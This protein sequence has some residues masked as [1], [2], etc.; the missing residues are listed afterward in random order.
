M[1]KH[2]FDVENQKLN[3]NSR[4]VVGFERMAEVFRVMLWNHARETGLSPIQIQ[5]LIFLDSHEESLRTV[6][7]LAKEFN[8]TKPTISDAIKTLSH[9]EL[10]SKTPGAEDARSYSVGLTNKGRAIVTEVEG[11]TL[12]LERAVDQFSETER[13]HLYK[14]LTKLVFQLHQSEVIAVQRTCFACKFHEEKSGGHYCHFINRDLKDHDI[15]L[16]CED[17]IS[18]EL[19]E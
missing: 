4:I 5:L 15:R 19:N 14:L 6:T 13:K 10:I 9:K 18:A 7:H 8:M 12:P 17:F 1:A 11:L 2:P 3:L 16:D